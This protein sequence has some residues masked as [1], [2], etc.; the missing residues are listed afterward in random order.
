MNAVLIYTYQR[1]INVNKQRIIIRC[2]EGDVAIFFEE[3][4]KNY[5]Y[6]KLFP[7]KRH[8]V[9]ERDITKLEF[10]FYTNPK[11][12]IMFKKSIL[13]ILTFK[14]PYND[15][16]NLRKTIEKYGYRTFDLS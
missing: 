16:N 2:K 3:C 7:N 5:T 13:N 4:A 10:V 8:C 12:I 6:E 9:G 1:I 15:F 11:T 14:S